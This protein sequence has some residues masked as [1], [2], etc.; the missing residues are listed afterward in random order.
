MPPF[1]SGSSDGADF[2]ARTPALVLRLDRNPFHHGTLGA[3]RSLGR[4]GVEVHAVVETAHSPAVRSR[5]LHRAHPGPAGPVDAEALVETLLRVS[6]R[7]GRRAV[8][9]AMDDLS[10]I[11]TAAHANRLRE[12]YCLPD[13][14]AEL[15]A[16]LADKAGLAGLCAEAGIA[17]PPTVVPRDGD[18]AAGAARTLGLPMVA[19]WSRPWLLG[20]ATGLRSTTL[21][22]S[23]EAA[24]ALWEQAGAAGSGLLLQRCIPGGPN[25]DWFFHGCFSRGPADPAS[26]GPADPASRGPV[27]P[28]CLLGGS[29]RKELSWP[30]RTGL[31][32]KGRWLPNSEVERAALRLVSHVGYRGILDLDFRRDRHT[33]A[34]QLLDVNP[35]PGAQFRLF[36]DRHGLDVVRALYL[37]VTG[38]PV[39]AQS[40]G[41]GRVFVAENYALLSALVTAG[42]A[43][44]RPV[45][46][47]PGP[48]PPP[49]AAVET[50]WYAS[51]DPLPFL[52][53]A[54]AWF[55]RGLAKAAHRLRPGAAGPGRRAH[56]AD[57]R[58]P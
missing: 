39:P 47:R 11:S 22:R 4:A 53:M 6:D 24:R 9:I 46:G 49:A 25:T 29:G 56:R 40:G 21:V 58:T 52:A 23:A 32:A 28:V 12:R 43:R 34:Y 1:G 35:R 33:G 18:E 30:V 10:A 50:A 16:R 20:A 44:G 41:P 37:D 2:D 38:Q 27:D 17:H 3:I 15:P 7:I 48:P 19:K 45:T 31:T 36:T 57:R 8:L 54:R 26:R 5:F 51:D 42:E 14:P 13:Q 55:G